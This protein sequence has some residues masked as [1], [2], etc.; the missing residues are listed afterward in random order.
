MCELLSPGGDIEKLKTAFIFGADAV[1]CGGPSMHLR[2]LDTSMTMRGLSDGI[3]YAHALGKKV[4]VTVNAFARNGDFIGLNEYLQELKAI[5]ADAII[6]SDL[7]VLSAA[8]QAVPE[9]PVHISTQANCLNYMSALMYYRL[10]AKRIILG[11]ELSLSEIREIRDKTPPELE[12]EVFVHGAMCMAYSGRCLISAYLTGRDS[13]RGDCAQPC[14][15][16]YRLIEEKRPDESYEI[17]QQ[18]NETT[19]LSSRDLNTLSFIHEIKAAGV[20]AFKIEG[21]MKSAFYVATV[22]NAYRRALDRSAP[23]DVLEREL[24]SVSHRDFTSGFYFGELPG[25]PPARDGYMRDCVFVA[26]VTGFKDGL[27]EVEQRNRFS[28]GEV[29]EV[30]S[31]DSIGK[32]LP[33][34]KIMDADM[35][36]MK[37]APHPRQKLYLSCGI[38]M[39]AGDLLRRRE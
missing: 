35:N 31:P 11:R 16:R 27:L 28:V 33:V 29:L 39:K 23:L 9:L 20:T 34:T 36:E 30:L 10:G 19:I 7:G 12:L 13:N 38:D 22:T 15:W 4:Y 37:S 26:V 8:V 24:R 6:V 14:R 21:R 2:A 32:M 17:R 5:G 3:E 1:Y 25:E 18:E